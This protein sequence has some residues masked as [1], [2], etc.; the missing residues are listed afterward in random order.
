MCAAEKGD[1][2]NSS[3]IRNYMITNHLADLPSPPVWKDGSGLSRYNLFTPRS[4]VVLLEKIKQELPESTLLALLPVGGTD[5][6][7]KAWYKSETG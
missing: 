7:L 2:L 1:T 3:R 5:G 6:T 4:M